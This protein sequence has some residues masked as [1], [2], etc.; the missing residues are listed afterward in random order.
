MPMM[1]GMSCLTARLAAG[2]G[3]DDRLG[4]PWGIGRR[5]PAIRMFGPSCARSSRT[6]ASKAAIRASGSVQPP[7]AA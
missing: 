4:R 1:A 3:L 2:G 7:D 5:G 6:W